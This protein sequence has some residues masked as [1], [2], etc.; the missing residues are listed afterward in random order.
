MPAERDAFESRLAK[1]REAMGL[2]GQ[3]TALPEK[4]VRPGTYHR[5]AL[6][7]AVEIAI[8]CVLD[9]GNQII[10]HDG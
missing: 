6:E 9:M 8:E 10:A 4:E 5:Y 2:M 3:L 1:L 7:R